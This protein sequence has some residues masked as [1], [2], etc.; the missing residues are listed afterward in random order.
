LNK[1]RPRRSPGPFSFLPIYD[2]LPL[3]VQEFFTHFTVPAA[4]SDP[5]LPEA[6]RVTVRFPFA[7]KLCDGLTPTPVLPSPKFHA[8]VVAFDEV[9]ALKLQVREEQV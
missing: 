8:N 1:K 5:P 9:P 2:P 4:V 3:L 7:E 6:V